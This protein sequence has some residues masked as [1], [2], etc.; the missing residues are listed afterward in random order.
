MHFLYEDV[1]KMFIGCSESQDFKNFVLYHLETLLKDID[2]SIVQ[3]FRT[4]KKNS[5]HCQRA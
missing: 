1:I 5:L 4:Y 3:Y 2:I